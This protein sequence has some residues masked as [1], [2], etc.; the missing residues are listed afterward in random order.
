M[1]DCKENVVSW[2]GIMFYL[3]WQNFCYYLWLI[4]NEFKHYAIDELF[5]QDHCY[6]KRNENK[7]TEVAWKTLEFAV[8]I[9]GTD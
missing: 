2:N 1:S 6:E 7:I 5:K 8:S 3:S 9:V 4:V